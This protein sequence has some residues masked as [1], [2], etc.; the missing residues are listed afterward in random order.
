MHTI[1]LTATSAEQT[2]LAG[3]IDGVRHRVG[4]RPWRSGRLRGRDVH[5]IEGGLGAVNTA[6]A[7]TCALQADLPD[8]VLQ[9]GVGG[10][11]PH[12][13][14]QV[15]DVALASEEVYGDLG[16]RTGAG[17]QPCELIGIPVWRDGESEFSTVSGWTRSWSRRPAPPWPRQGASRLSAPSSR[18][19]NAAA[20]PPRQGAGTALRSPVREH[21]RGGGRPRQQDLRRPLSSRYAGSATGSRT[22]PSTPGTSPWQRGRPSPRRWPPWRNSSRERAG[23]FPGVFPLPQRHLHLLRP[24]AGPAAGGAR[25]PR[26]PRGYRDPERDGA[27]RRPRR[28]QGVLPRP[29]PPQGGVLPAPFRRGPRPRLRPPGRGEG[30]PLPGGSRGPKGCDP[31]GADH[32]GAAAAA[33]RPGLARAG[34]PAVSRDHAGGEGRPRRRRRHHPREPLHLPGLRVEAG[35]RPRGVVGA[36]RQAVRSPWAASRRGGSWEPKRSPP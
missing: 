23:L 15:G 36:R 4:G 25:V 34:N 27:A 22:A 26:D 14:L 32:G 12:T 1:L 3:E 16:V 33:V 24:R 28:R 30:S 8:L 29:R 18:S 17:W 5:L 19:R 20:A 7:L 6:Q 13:P 31:G 10:G 9:V 11:Y 2:L 21:G 35:R